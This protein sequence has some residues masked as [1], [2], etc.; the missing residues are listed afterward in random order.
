MG[1]LDHFINAAELYM[2]HKRFSD[3]QKAEAR[4]A[5]PKKRRAKGMGK[6]R[7]ARGP[8]REFDGGHD[9]ESDPDCCVA[10]R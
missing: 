10:K 5:Q 4:A 3:G 8:G 9:D 7:A 2:K 6:T 1:F